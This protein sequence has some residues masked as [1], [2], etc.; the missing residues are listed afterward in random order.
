MVSVE[1]ECKEVLM[2]LRRQKMSNE[3]CYYC[4]NITES[5]QTFCAQSRDFEPDIANCL[6]H[7]LY[8]PNASIL[9]AGVQNALCQSYGVKKL[10]P[11]SH[12]FISSHFIEDFPGRTFMIEDSCCFTKKDLKRMLADINQCNLTVRNFPAT[13]AELRKRLKLREGGNI[14]LFATTLSDNSHVLIRCRQL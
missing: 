3:A 13:V 4:T 2:V 10:H 14:Y 8:E 6:D 12:L 7:Y 11:F 1:S 5:V 9:K